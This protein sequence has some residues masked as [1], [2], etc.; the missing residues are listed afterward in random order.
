MAS[1]NWGLYRKADGA[2][3]Y[4]P[5]YLCQRDVP[6]DVRG[7]SDSRGDPLPRRFKASTGEIVLARAERVARELWEKWGEEIAAARAAGPVHR[8][9]L[10]GAQAAIDLWRVLECGNAA[11][12]SLPDRPASPGAS[13]KLSELGVRTLAWSTLDPNAGFAWAQT[14]FAA[15]PNASRSCDLSADV[16]F[17]L[18]Q[19]TEAARTEDGWAAI[20]GFDAELDTTLKAGGASGEVPARLRDMLRQSYAKAALE[21]EQHR[22]HQRQRAALLSA[23]QA[24]AMASPDTLRPAPLPGAYVARAGD[25][26][27]AQLIAKVTSE[28]VE[29]QVGANRSRDQAEAYV[30]KTYGPIYSALEELF[31]PDQPARK[32]LTR[33]GALE[34][35]KLLNRMPANAK[36]FYPKATLREAIELAEKDGRALLSPDTRRNYM[37]NLVAI[38]NMGVR[39]GWLDSN[40][41]A[42]LKGARAPNVRRRGFLGPELTQ[43]FAGLEAERGKERWWIVAILTFSGARTGEVCQLEVSDVRELD[44]CWYLDLSRFDQDGLVVQGKRLKTGTS[45]RAVPLHATLIEAG[46]LDF[47]ARAKEAGQERLFPSIKPH[48]SGSWS[49]E[50]SKWFGRY[51]DKIGLT[52]RSLTLHSLRHGFRDAGRA[53]GLNDNVIDALG[54]WAPS[55]VGERY[56]NRFAVRVNQ[57]HMDKIAF[58]GFTL[59][60]A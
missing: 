10:T 47:V 50:F 53:A 23:S 28:K 26:T 16:A 2:G 30:K 57:G 22:E 59:L 40:P 5:T 52:A 14:Y 51:C 11:R 15:H 58:D 20:A 34:V 48:A 19:L 33:D 31:G 41:T 37:G 17:R 39:A 36:K 7:R 25:L 13:A 12:F 54:G 55:N 49:H 1:R 44:G 42:G 29:Q 43:V 3:G 4:Y 56:G 35:R 45:E 32:V 9:N 18:S 8:L 6:A 38:M 24:V 46:F 60:A 21:V 27:V